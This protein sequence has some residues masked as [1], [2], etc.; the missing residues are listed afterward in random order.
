MAWALVTPASRGIGL[1]L[2][3]HLLFTTPP[4]LPIVATARSNPSGTKARILDGLNLS[5][6]HSSRLDVQKIDF[7]SE[8][9]IADTA[10]YCKDRYNDRS[11]SKSPHLR[12]ALLVPGML[13]PERAPDKILY[14]AALAT[15]K[16]NLLAPMMLMKHFAAFL[17]RKT[18]ELEHVEGL[19][20]AAL[21]A[22]MSARVGSISDNQRGGWYATGPR[23]RV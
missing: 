7:D 20:D 22:F 13:I 23:K 16:L 17:P 5:P 10:A 6:S 2:A 9:S 15:L 19:N 18:T 1:A 3:R 14:D 8:S 12:L 4:S 11:K 21:M